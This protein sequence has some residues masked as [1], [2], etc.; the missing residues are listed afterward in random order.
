MASRFALPRKDQLANL[1]RRTPVLPNYH[2]Q[3]APMEALVK[4]GVFIAFCI[5]LGLFYGFAFTILPP[6][7]A[8]YLTAPMLLLALLIIWALP[9]VGKAPVGVLSKLL[10]LYLV[11]LVLWPNY[12]ALQLPGLP[13][14]SF[15]RLIMFPMSL[16]L[17]ICLS[18][19]ARFRAELTDVLR[20][21]KPLTYMVIGFTAI[22][23]LTLALTGSALFFSL[24]VTVNY[25]FGTTAAFFAAAWV[26]RQP[27]RVNWA[28][29]AVLFM[30]FFLCVMAVLEFRNQGVLWANHIPTFLQVEDGAWIGIFHGRDQRDHDRRFRV[31]A[32]DM[33]AGA[34]RERKR[35]VRHLAGILRGAQHRHDGLV[36]HFGL[37]SGPHEPCACRNAITLIGIKRPPWPRRFLQS[38]QVYHVRPQA[39]EIPRGCG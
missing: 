39:P 7:L 4:K 18:V 1:F 20:S 25:L 37:L 6:Q 13:W 38:S 22:Q 23:I 33:P 8:L 11:V 26:F 29:N 34:A 19:S 5:G 32:I 3:R 12:L 36:A 9:D 17:L 30:A 10:T 2:A 14:I 35:V 27:R 15:R 31:N 21:A 16:I 24:N 28:I